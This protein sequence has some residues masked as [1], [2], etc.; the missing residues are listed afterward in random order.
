MANFSKPQVKSKFQEVSEEA[1]TWLVDSRNK[2][3]ELMLQLHLHPDLP[4]KGEWQNHVGAAFSLWRAVFLCHD[5]KDVSRPLAGDA[6]KFLKRVIERNTILFGD[7][8]DAAAWTGA[9][10]I[11]NAK[12]RLGMA[13]FARPKH[14]THR[15]R[16][17]ETFDELDARVRKSSKRSNE[18]Y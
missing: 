13:T 12:Y 9:Y 2:I 14:D 4:N 18:E 7:D 5:S 3:Q 10:Y 17:E 8:R 6:K 1:L 15:E 16:W 11:N